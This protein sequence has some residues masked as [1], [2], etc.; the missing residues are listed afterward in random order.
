[1]RRLGK[2]EVILIV[3][4]ANLIRV[5]SSA[6][7]YTH[8]RHCR[9]LSKRIAP[10][11]TPSRLGSHQSAKRAIC[12]RVMNS[13]SLQEHNGGISKKHVERRYASEPVKA[14]TAQTAKGCGVM[15]L[16]GEARKL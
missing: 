3:N 12:R 11:A 15:A 6:P 4:T 7:W 5:S 16:I 9:E 10:E 14:G 2:F 8:N 13:R 1:M